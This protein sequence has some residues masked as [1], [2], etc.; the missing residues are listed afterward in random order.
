M[1]AAA[2][3]G[4]R[5]AGPG[6]GDGARALARRCTAVCVCVCDCVPLHG[7]HSCVCVPRH[8]VHSCVCARQGCVR[9]HICVRERDGVCSLCGCAHL[10]PDTCVCVKESVPLRVL[11]LCVRVCAREGSVRVC[12]GGAPSAVRSSPPE[13]GVCVCVCV[14]TVCVGG[15]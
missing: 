5:A 11:H 13:G 4:P 6:R 10:C 9:V 1:R 12:R 14:G 2:G 7:V 3:A 15:V 8:G